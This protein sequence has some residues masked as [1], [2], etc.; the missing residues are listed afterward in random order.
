MDSVIQRIIQEINSK[1][2][3]TLNEKIRYAYLELGKVVHLNSE[4]FYSLYGIMHEDCKLSFT[5]LKEI[6]ENEKPTYDVICKDCSRMLKMIFDGCN[7]K[8]DIKETIEVNQYY[9]ENERFDIQHFFNV[10]EGDNGQQYFLS[11]VLDIP[12]IQLGLKTEHFG[13]NIVYVDDKGNQVY[14]GE[15]I[16]N[17]V[18][19]PNYIKQMDEKIGYLSLRFEDEKDKLTYV[20][21]A[22][23]KLAEANRKNKMYYSMLALN[24]NNQFYNGLINVMSEEKDYLSVQLYDMDSK[25]I[26]EIKKYVCLSIKNKIKESILI[27]EAEIN[28]FYNSLLNQ[29]YIECINILAEI[30]KKNDYKTTDGQFGLNALIT[31]SLKFFSVLDKIPNCINYTPDELDK[32]KTMLN[33]YIYKLA[34]VY[35]PKEYLP[36]A[37]YNYSNKYLENKLKL[38]FPEIFDFNSDTDFTHMKVGEKGVI[39]SRVMHALFQ[40]LSNDKTIERKKEDPIE[41]RINTCMMYDKQEGLYKFLLNIEQNS[42]ENDIV[43][44]YNFNDGYNCFEEQDLSILE[45]KSNTDRYM[46]LSKKINI[47][48][49]QNI[50]E[51]LSR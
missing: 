46:L 30:L 36:E 51:N 15:E 34:K 6:Y 16:K 8:S 27:T 14:N 1:T 29:N 17:I 42:K 31:N 26:H 28:Q 5:N 2:D 25:K 37:D 41:N 49:E 22:F 48:A 38:L 7:I 9:L 13:T 24:I 43:L 47:P 21:S 35:I 23:T 12:L 20:N 50:E 10:V 4:F 3:W 45:L 39:I 19:D 11:L 44:I 18:L 33:V 32:L 40:E